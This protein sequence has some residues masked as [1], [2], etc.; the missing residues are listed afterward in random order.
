MSMMSAHTVR[1]HLMVSGLV[2]ALAVAVSAPAHADNHQQNGQHGKLSKQVRD[3]GKAK[4]KAKLD[5]LVRFR[6]DPGVSERL[7]V[8]LLGGEVRRKHESRWSTVRLPGRNVEELAELGV[9][10]F[11]ATDA[12]IS[13][14]LDVSREVVYPPPPDQP[15]TLLKGT[16]VTVALLD[17]GVAAHPEIQTLVAAVDFV[18]RYDPTFAPGGS[19][20]TNGHG[21]HVAGILVGN[22]SRSSGQFTGVAPEAS[23]V[24]VRVLNDQGQGR[25]SD[26][27]AGLQWILDHKDAYGI[28]VLNLSLG[29]PIYEAAEVDPL[30]QAVE[31]LW[32]AGVVVVCA[33]GNAGRSGNGT[34]SSPC[35]SRKVITVGALNERKTFDGLDDMITTY[36]SRGPTRINLIAKP[37]ILAPGNKIVS[38]RAAGSYLDRLLAGRQIAADAGLPAVQE[39]LEM[40]GTSMAAPFVAGAAALM[41][42]QDPTLNP[43]T[44][45]A[46]LML[47]AKKVA[48][49]DPFATGAGLLDVLAA[50]RATG[51]VAD[52]PS[53]RVFPDEVAGTITVE[54]TGTLWSDAAFSLVHL[55]SSAVLWSD[56]PDAPLLSTYAVLWTD[57]NG[58]L[59]PDE[60]AAA[61]ASATLWG[62]STL[63]S[64]AVLWTDEDLLPVPVVLGTLNSLIE[65][66]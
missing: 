55:W 52:A 6:Q 39:H 16:G 9:V 14:S 22:G 24:S 2:L 18:G 43:G 25:T 51:R 49:G 37:D 45:K 33:A 23:L 58:L 10:E 31:R 3:E 63:W 41:V 17:S 60:V 7:L 28:R 53:P 64:Q 27:L 12:L 20:D 1:R 35:N 26:M 13:A 40:S 30:V 46:R 61:A 57:S 29:H 32:D 44:V 65:D 50:L 47:S 34:I 19:I 62:E 11:V 38:A 59:W 42:Q 21:T 8:Q 54:N 4:G 5:V 36:S 15:E 48:L 66:P 56:A